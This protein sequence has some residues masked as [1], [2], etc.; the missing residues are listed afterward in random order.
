M[1]T[2][3][4]L[5]SPTFK[6]VQGTGKII[7]QVGSSSSYG[8]SLALQPDGKILVAGYSSGSGG[9]NDFS[10]IRLNA[11]GSLDSSFDIDGKAIISVGSGID[12]AFSVTVQPDGKI[13]LAGSSDNGGGNYDF[14]LVRL[15]PNGSLD[16]TFDADGKAI[17][18]VGS[19]SDY[20][21]SVSLQTDGKILVAGYSFGTVGINNDL[22]LIRLNADGSLDTTFDT[23]GKVIIPSGV[24]AAEANSLTIQ[25]D[26]KILVAG[27][28]NGINGYD[29][30]LIRLNADGSLDTTFDADGRAIIPVGSSTDYGQSVSLQ[31]DGKILVAGYSSGT[32]GING[33]N[34]DFSLI[35]L[36]SDGS[37][38]TTFDT[39]GKVIIPVGLG[40]D[41]ANTI[42]LQPD[43]KI[44]VA[45][46][47]F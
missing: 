38:G 14:S 31:P 22:S 17:I 9:T 44:L 7:V 43:G 47:S 29:F 45:G 25:P 4:N 19:L 34:Y 16:T 8:Q 3:L 28:S 23:D 27:Y 24:G 46:Y 37:L 10:L 12:Q 42:T 18:P 41:Q 20:G 21:R 15:N 5:N 6:G 36:N 2:G 13:I 33:P 1:A 40:N 30:S 26:G 39:D 32:F 11:D 35:R